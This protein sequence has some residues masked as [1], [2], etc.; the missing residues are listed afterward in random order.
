LEP[1]SQAGRTA[2]G[3]GPAPALIAPGGRLSWLFAAPVLL[4]VLGTLGY[5]LLEGWPLFD[6]FYVTVL[7][8]TTIGF[9]GALSMNTAGQAFTAGLA[10][11][12]VFTFFYSATAVI[13]S[14]VSG[15]LTGL[16]ERKRM[17]KALAKLERHVVVCGY[18]R[19]GRFVCKEFAAQRVPYVVVERDEHAAQD[20]PPPGDGRLLIGDAT[21]E[22]ILQQLGIRRARA[23]VS[24]LGSDADNLYITMSARLMNDRLFI[25]AR[26]ETEEAEAKLLRAGAN[27]VIAPYVLGGTHVAHAVMR[28]TVLEFIE[29]ATRSE[30]LDLQMEEIRIAEGSRLHTA[31]I[32]DSGIREDYGAIVVAIKKPSGRMVFNPPPDHVIEAGAI[33][34]ALGPPSEL[35]RLARTAGA[36]AQT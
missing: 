20:A 32:K 34:I 14:V 6:C 31:T 1:S 16:L 23:L 8:L 18:G 36:G 15:E 7:T 4:L 19:M 24:V 3:R 28:P 26:S 21:S 30:H 2:P 27:R 25:V 9:N 29:L 22:E 12:G 13:S 5:R 33:L 17:E 35:A 10:L 11:I